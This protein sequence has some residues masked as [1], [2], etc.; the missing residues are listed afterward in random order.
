MSRKAV[1]QVQCSRCP[2]VETIEADPQTA[3]E[4]KEPDFRA[5]L[6]IGTPLEKEIL[7]EDLCSTCR[8][9]ISKALTGVSEVTKVSAKR[10]SKKK[11]QETHEP[12]RPAVQHNGPP[13]PMR[14]PR[15]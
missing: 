11:A 12:P 14:A 15:G 13:P 3:N 4:K 10:T 8:D 7:Y 6:C 1:V 9:I 2:R 5:V